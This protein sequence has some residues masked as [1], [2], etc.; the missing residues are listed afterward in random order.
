MYRVSL[1]RKTVILAL[2]IVLKG[3]VLLAGVCP[4]NVEPSGP[5]ATENPHVSCLL[6]S[7]ICVP[8]TWISIQKRNF[9]L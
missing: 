9:P 2:H 8:S 5:G 3:F 4:P 6:C 1:Q 7:Q